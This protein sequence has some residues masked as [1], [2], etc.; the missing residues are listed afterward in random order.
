MV[1]ALR[2]RAPA[3]SFLAWTGGA[4]F[5]LFLHAETSEPGQEVVRSAASYK[6]DAKALKKAAFAAFFSFD[7]RSVVSRP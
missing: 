2:K 3:G 5:R 1:Q 4:M 7:G 6:P